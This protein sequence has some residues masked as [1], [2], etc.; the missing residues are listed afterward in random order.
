MK[1]YWVVGIAMAA[2]LSAQAEECNVT[3]YVHTSLSGSAMLLR[4]EIQAA[5]MF[6]EIGVAVRFR[7][8]AVRAN[9]ANDACGAPIMLQIDSQAGDQPPAEHTLAYATPY[10]KSG[11]CI[12]IFMDRI[13]ERLNPYFE[14]VLLAHVL[15]H[16]ITHVLERVA[17]H[18]ADGVM[19]AHWD[20][21]D[22]EDMKSHSLPFAAIDVELIH[23]GIAERTHAGRDG[24]NATAIIPAPRMAPERWQR[25]EQLYH[26]A[27]EQTPERRSA[28][29][30]EA[31]GGDEALRGEV[32][33][34]LQQPDEGV[35]D[36][37]ER[38]NGTSNRSRM[39]SCIPSIVKSRPTSRKLEGSI[40]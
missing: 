40:R 22:K 23:I 32:E 29:L 38:T 21:R 17:R 2:G 6:R 1:T 33:S 20:R 28:F 4:A 7:N 25:I 31:S 35:L 5:A 18:S 27:L 39:G 19:K 24:M 9:D 3:V 30:E 14:T 37:L 12:H 16:E 8:G 10:A 26:A 13:A 34:L 36:S 11:T 15:A